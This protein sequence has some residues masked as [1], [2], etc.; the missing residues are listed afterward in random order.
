MYVRI[1]IFQEESGMKR[2]V[3]LVS[4]VLVF[5]AS[6]VFAG[7]GNQGSAASGG[8]GGN[9]KL[10][11][12]SPPIETTE[13]GLKQW[14]FQIAEFKKRYPNVDLELEQQPPGIDYRQ[15]YDKALM[16]GTV[17]TVVTVFPPVDI[18]T[19]A[20]NGTIK[21]VSSLVE[22]WDLRKQ[23]LVNSAFDEALVID[24]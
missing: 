7:G 10:K 16:A 1:Y 17:P 6:L 19:R 21:D 18:P 3:L 8:S 14:D 15:A 12:W 5:S 11:L 9:V 4:F 13:A 20:K 22:N 24:N 23:G 2:F